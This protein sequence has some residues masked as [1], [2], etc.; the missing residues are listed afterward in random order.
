MFF[1]G[2]MLLFFL[3]MLRFQSFNVDIKSFEFG[4]LRFS[5][6]VWL[7]MVDWFI[8]LVLVINL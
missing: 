2:L 7:F 6:E 3:L 5:Y 1:F 4:G 8:N